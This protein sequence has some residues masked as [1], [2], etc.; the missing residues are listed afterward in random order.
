M[1]DSQTSRNQASEDYFCELGTYRPYAK[2]QLSA[3]K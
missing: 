3:W 1:G 2:K